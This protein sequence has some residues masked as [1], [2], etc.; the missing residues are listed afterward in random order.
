MLADVTGCEIGQGINTKV[1]QAVAYG[2]GCPVD[3]VTVGD[4]SSIESP[5]STS[6]GDS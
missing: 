1:A 6:T 2:L 5:N 4:I 3:V